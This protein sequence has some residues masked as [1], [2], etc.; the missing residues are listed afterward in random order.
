[1]STQAQTLALPATS[2]TLRNSTELLGRI[3]LSTLF[4]MSGLGKIAAYSVTA[5]YM[6][7]QGVPGVLL[8][9]VI[10]T[11]VGGAIA[12]ITGW[13]TRIVAIL[14]AGFTVLAALMFHS[15]FGD[16]NQMIHFMKNLSIAGAFLMLA[17]N[18]AGRYSLDARS[19]R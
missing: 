16:Q 2:A 18:G 6:A 3:L 15:H 7:S 5:G 12:I 9:L 11:E 19:G 4:L 14:M 13:H 10:L 8:P 17:V 1:M